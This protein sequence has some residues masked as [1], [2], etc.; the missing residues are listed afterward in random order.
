MCVKARFYLLCSFFFVTAFTFGQEKNFQIPDSLNGKDFT[1][2]YNRYLQ[3]YKDTISVKIYLNTY[4][5]K[6]IIEKDRVSQSIALNELSYYT[7]D[8]I[9]KLDLIHKSLS[10]SNSVDSLYS[11]AAY[12]H[13]GMY[14]QSNYEYGKAL[15]QHLRVLRLSEKNE[16]DAY[17]IIALNSIASVKKNVGKHKEALSLY[18]RSLELQQKNQTSGYNAIIPI[19]VHIA[20]SYRD[21]KKYDSASYYYTIVKENAQKEDMY[22]LNIATINEGINL[23]YKKHFEEAT[24]LIQKGIDEANYNDFYGSRHHILSQFYLGKI[25]LPSNKKI[26][27]EYFYNVDSLLTATHTAIPEV[28][29]IYEYLITEYKTT[30]NHREHLST[31]NKLMQFDSIANSRKLNIVDKLYSGFDTPEL[32]KDKERLIQTLESKN[33]ILSTKT[34]IIILFFSGFIILFIIQLRKHQ[35]YKKRFE[36]ILKESTT[37]SKHSIKPNRIKTTSENISID[38]PVIHEVLKKLKVFETKN[39]FLKNNITVTSLAK[40]LS[41]NTKYLSKIIN[42]HKGKSFIH[43]INDL[44]VDYMVKELKINATLQRYTILSIA[45]EAGFNSAKSFSDA[46]KKKTGITPTYYIKNLKAKKIVA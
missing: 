37:N 42:T 21:N 30:Q 29:E 31:I 39:D 11:I 34:F 33:Q 41:T 28:R 23:Y 43:Y 5:K 40:K 17:Q 13:L 1:Y 35:V 45:K 44:R 36:A 26:A 27:K 7:I 24:L 38:A 8:T 10:I 6:A 2:L 14:Y 9:T 16:Y 22:F 20:E 19:T 18:K 12:N 25:H 3:E 4:Y 46:F 15:Q 32:L